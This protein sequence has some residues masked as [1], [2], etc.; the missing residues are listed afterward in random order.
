[1]SSA[2]SE[3]SNIVVVEKLNKS[4]GTTHVLRDIDLSISNGETVVICGASGSGKS[5]LLRCMNGLETHD[6]G[7]ITVLGRELTR[8]NLRDRAFRVQVGMVFQKFSLFPHMSILQ[9]LCLAPVKVLRRP[10][11]EVEEDARN[12]LGRVGLSGKIDAWPQELSGGQ[13]Q[14]VAIARAL[15]LKPRLL[16]FDEPTSAL[17]PETI[18]EVLDVMR[19]LAEGGMNLVVVTHELGFAREVADR[20]VFM[21]EG[22]IEEI[23]SAEQF[24]TA[25]KS[26]RAKSFINQIL[27]H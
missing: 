17:D 20:I 9:N 16:L 8:K 12:I 26:S 3:A 2:S 23:S 4:F 24:F 11:A 6:S 22:Q 10:R 21:D 18:R 5:T 27:N 19:S 7:S 25:P 15:I 14:R 13:Q 1:M